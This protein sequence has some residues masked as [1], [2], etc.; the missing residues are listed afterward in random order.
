MTQRTNSFP[1]LN[2]E[3]REY[4][5]TECAAFHLMRRPQTLREAHCSG[6]LPPAIRP[7]RLNGRLAWSVAAIQA[8]L[9][10]GVA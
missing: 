8:Y 4:V 7:K 10:S 6:T 2:D 5:S 1:S 9:Q 3:T